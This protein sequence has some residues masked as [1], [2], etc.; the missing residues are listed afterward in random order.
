MQYRSCCKGCP[1]RCVGCRSECE[2]WAL[3]E[4]EKAKLYAER[5]VQFNAHY[6]SESYWKNVCESARRNK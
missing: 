3:H 2:A 6:T 1:N 5:N 4:E